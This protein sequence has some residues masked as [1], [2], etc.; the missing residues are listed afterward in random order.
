MSSH[1]TTVVLD[2]TPDA[3]WAFATDPWRY[4]EWVSSTRTVTFVSD[5]PVGLGSTFRERSR[6][7]LLS[8]RR[9]WTITGWEPPTCQVR[10]SRPLGAAV[11]VTLE[12]RSVAEGTELRLLTVVRPP[13]PL[14]PFG[15]FVDRLIG[16][17]VATQ[18]RRTARRAKAVFEC[19]VDGSVT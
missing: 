16:P 11:V 1:E 8:L 15:R 19:G 2:G 3:V 5:D 6:L 4:P 7:G 10:E 18:S 14:G 12:L 9:E 13:R 17:A